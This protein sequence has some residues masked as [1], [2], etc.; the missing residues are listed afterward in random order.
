MSVLYVILAI[1]S[2]GLLIV[3]HE[4]GHFLTARLFGVGINEFSIGMGP[5]LFSWKGKARKS[6][7]EQVQ[8]DAPRTEFGYDADGNVMLIDEVASG[9]M[10]VYKNG[11]YVDPMTLNKL[12]FA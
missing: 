8:E 4:L 3:L 5:K 7:K 6:N 1:L 12:F 2:F 11:E 10:R 9:N